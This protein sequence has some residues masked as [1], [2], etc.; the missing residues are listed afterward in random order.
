MMVSAHN[1]KNCGGHFG[2]HKMM[3]L[4]DMIELRGREGSVDLPDNLLSQLESECE[5]VG[6]SLHVEL[7]SA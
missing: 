5:R 2:A 1:L 7:G 6:K 4:C 3:A